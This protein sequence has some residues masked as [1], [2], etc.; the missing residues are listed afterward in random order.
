MSMT[1]R[2]WRRSGWPLA[3]SAQ[4][5]NESADSYAHLEDAMWKEVKR[6]S[7]I[8]PKQLNSDW[9]QG[10]GQKFQI[11]AQGV[12]H[13]IRNLQRNQSQ[14]KA[15]SSG[16]LRPRAKRSAKAKAKAKAKHSARRRS[17]RS[18]ARE[19]SPMRDVENASPSVEPHLKGSRGL[20]IFI[21]FFYESL[22]LPTRH[23]FVTGLAV[24]DKMLI[25]PKSI[26]ERLGFSFR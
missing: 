23:Y 12:E 1:S 8:G 3:L 24:Y 20:Q 13:C 26:S 16:A 4:L 6:R 7:M 14:G 10:L 5:S 19:T 18:E 25:F 15:R 17:D 22:F 2:R 11:R 21:N 9:F